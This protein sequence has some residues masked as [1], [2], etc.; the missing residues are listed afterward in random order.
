MTSESEGAGV[1]P[2]KHRYVV[3]VEETREVE[4]LVYASDAEEAK[5]SIREGQGWRESDT[6]YEQRIIHVE[7]V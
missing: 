3:T 1:L 6:F 2:E 4:Y 7:R 5:E